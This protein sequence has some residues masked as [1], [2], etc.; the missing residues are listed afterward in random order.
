M[1]SLQVDPFFQDDHLKLKQTYCMKCHTVN[2]QISTPVQ[3]SAH[4]SLEPP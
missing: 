1:E 3:F 2:V 4:S